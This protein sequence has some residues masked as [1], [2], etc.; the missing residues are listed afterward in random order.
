VT[1]GFRMNVGL[2]WAATKQEKK[3]GPMGSKPELA[4]SDER[5]GGERRGYSHKQRG[6][7]RRAAVD[8]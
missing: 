8:V 2:R 3:R 4:G 7:E 5:V 6:R 1:L